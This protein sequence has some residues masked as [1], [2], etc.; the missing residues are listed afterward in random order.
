MSGGIERSAYSTLFMCAENMKK[1][2]CKKTLPLPLNQTGI[3]TLTLYPNQINIK[4]AKFKL[5]LIYYC[6]SLILNAKK[7]SKIPKTIAPIPARVIK[8]CPIAN[9]LNNIKT[10]KTTVNNPLKRKRYFPEV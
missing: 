4:I 2:R 7:I 10:P 6:L 5:T 9:G 8:N 3:L 1:V